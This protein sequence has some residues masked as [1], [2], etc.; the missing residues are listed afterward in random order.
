[1]ACEADCGSSTVLEAL[2]V[3]SRVG[4]FVPGECWV[5]P[6]TRR[7]APVPRRQWV[8]GGEYELGDGKFE[9]RNSKFEIP[10]R[11]G[12]LLIVKAF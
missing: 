11:F 2:R 9:I 3:A 7:S 5:A 4:I 8:P 6:V 12:K 10:Q 1:M